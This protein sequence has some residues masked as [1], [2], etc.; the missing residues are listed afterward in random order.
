[1]T[2]SLCF[3]IPAFNEEKTI[4]SVIDSIKIEFPESTIVVINDNSTDKT[5]FFAHKSGVITIDLIN[6]LGIGGAVQTGLKFASKSEFEFVIQMD[7]DGQHL[8]S[9]VKTLL[10]PLKVNRADY[11]IGSRWLEETEY[12]SSRSRRLGIIFLSRI[13]TKKAGKR[14]TDVTSGFRAMSKEVAQVLAMNYEKDFPE[15]SAILKIVGLGYRV[16]EVPVTMKERT[17]GESSITRLKS[18]YYMT[19]ETITILITR[20]LKNEH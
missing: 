20:N 12:K 10:H 4:I 1:M 2:P 17:H 3:V 8:A 19:L 5:G 6:N 15:I 9:E 11:V 16:E 14:F 13:T 18:L 7:S